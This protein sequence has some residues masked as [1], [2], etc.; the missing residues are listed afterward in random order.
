MDPPLGW[1]SDGELGSRL[2]IDSHDRSEQ[3][4]V[5]GGVTNLLGIED[6]FLELSSLG[7]ALDNLVGNIRAQV[8]AEGKG[9]VGSLDHVT[10]LLTALQLV[11]LQPL[12]E[13][14][15]APLGQDWPAE[16]K[17]LELVELALVEQDPKILKQW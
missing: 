4:D 17:G 8:D 6:N 3:I 13:E 2:R 14:L 5:V 7:E 15:L 12:L 10:Q 9:G 1:L 16:L 11:L